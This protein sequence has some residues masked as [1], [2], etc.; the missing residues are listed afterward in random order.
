MALRASHIILYS[1]LCR[2]TGGPPAD[3][4]SKCPTL[5]DPLVRTCRMGGDY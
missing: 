3:R 5:R 2:V 1:L 4:Q